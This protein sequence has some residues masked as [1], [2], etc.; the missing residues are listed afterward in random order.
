M[1]VADGAGRFSKK[2]WPTG[3][4]EPGFEFGAQILAE[5]RMRAAGRATADFD[6]MCGDM[7]GHEHTRT[8]KLGGNP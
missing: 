7:V 2:A 5:N 4:Q 3:A 6:G 1:V 8:A